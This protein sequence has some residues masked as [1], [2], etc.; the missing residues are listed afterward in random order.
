M[1]KNIHNLWIKIIKVLIVSFFSALCFGDKGIYLLN[2]GAYQDTYWRTGFQYGNSH[3][4]VYLTMAVSLFLSTDKRDVINILWIL[5]LII[6]KI[7]Y[8]LGKN[9]NGTLLSQHKTCE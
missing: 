7:L 8:K 5:Y 9:K 4:N 2:N 1:N 6:I 3:I